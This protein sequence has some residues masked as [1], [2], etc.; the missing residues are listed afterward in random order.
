MADSMAS[1]ERTVSTRGKWWA[2]QLE[3]L[4]TCWPSRNRVLS[5]K[6]YSKVGAK[7]WKKLFGGILIGILASYAGPKAKKLYI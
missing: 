6:I 7:L 3:F 2:L 5:L 1:P 4:G